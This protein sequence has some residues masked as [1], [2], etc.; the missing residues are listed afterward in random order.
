MSR[1]DDII[2]G[3]G[4]NGADRRGLSRPGWSQGPGARAHGSRWSRCRLS[5]GLSGGVDAK[6]SRYSYLVSLLPRRVIADLD[7]GLTLV[8]RRY[9]SFTPLPSAPSQGLLVDNGDEAAT[10]AAFFTALTDSGAEYQQW[11]RSYA[12]MT[13]LAE[14]VFP[15]VLEP[16]RS[17][18]QVRACR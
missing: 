3:A 16:L 15:T 5:P 12:R 2:L 7:L 17:K 11:Q 8:R 13:S 18:A 1:Y 4:H 6:L 9:S 14:R 10:S